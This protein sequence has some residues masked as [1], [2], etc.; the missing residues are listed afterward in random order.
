MQAL[1]VPKTCWQAA[2]RTNQNLQAHAELVLLQSCEG[3]AFVRC[4]GLLDLHSYTCCTQDYIPAWDPALAGSLKNSAV[5]I[6]QSFQSYRSKKLMTLQGR[7]TKSKPAR[8]AMSHSP[9]WIL[10]AIKTCQPRMSRSAAR[11]EKGLYSKQRRRTAR[12]DKGRAGG[13][14]PTL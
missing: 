2:F 3:C 14:G 8:P 10:M 13:G 5:H 11:A 4:E 1:C 12:A 6:Q 7:K 9:A